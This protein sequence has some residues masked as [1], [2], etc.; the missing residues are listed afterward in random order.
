MSDADGGL[1][2]A[3]SELAPDR[4]GFFLTFTISEGDRYKVGKITINS[5]LRNLNGDALRD[6]L[7]IDSGDW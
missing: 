5:Q 7:Q 4:S 6:N 3:K 2:D 1:R